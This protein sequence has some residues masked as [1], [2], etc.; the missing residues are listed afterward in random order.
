MEEEEKYMEF[1]Q[2]LRVLMTNAKKADPTLVL[3]PVQ[4]GEGG[5]LHEPTE[6]PFNYTNM[7]LHIKVSGGHMSFQMKKQWKDNG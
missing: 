6:I 7:G 5:Q 1:T 3:E 4:P 2:A